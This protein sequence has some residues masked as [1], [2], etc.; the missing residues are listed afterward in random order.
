MNVNT[1]TSILKDVSAEWEKLGLEL[2]VKWS[3]I[4]QIARSRNHADPQLCMA[5]LLDCWLRSGCDASWEKVASALDEIE[6]RD[7]ALMIRKTYCSPGKLPMY[8]I[9]IDLNKLS[10]PLLVS[11]RLNAYFKSTYIT[12]C[13]SIQV[14]Q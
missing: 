7:V 10:P 5:D 1:L 4:K 8:S 6:I 2:G 12:F 11:R 13:P 14:I 9:G 3:K